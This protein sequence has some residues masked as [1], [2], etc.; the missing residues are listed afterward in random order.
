MTTTPAPQFAPDDLYISPFSKQRTFD[1]DSGAAIYTPIERN[2]SPT[3]VAILDAYARFLVSGKRYSSVA[4]A[5]SQGVDS[6]DFTALCRILVGMMPEELHHHL[7]FRYADELL[8][9]TDL[10]ITQIARLCSANDA[11]NLCRL[12]QKRYH[13][14]PSER[15][16]ALRQR[17]DLGRL[18]V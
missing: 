6:C 16:R 1:P 15:R 11:S 13:C 17:G 7:L 2:M 18:A 8:R 10:T 3:G 4:F 9:Y 14:S 5:K 12:M